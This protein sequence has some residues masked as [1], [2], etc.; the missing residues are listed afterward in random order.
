[1]KRVVLF[2]LA[3]LAHAGVLTLSGPVQILKG[4][5][6]PISVT[7]SG[8]AAYSAV[9]FTMV[10]P[11]DVIGVTVIPGPVAIA[12]QKSAR[13]GAIVSS[14]IS[15]IVAGFLGNVGATANS[16]AMADGVVAT[17]TVTLLANP[18][19][20]SE[21]FTLQPVSGANSAG[22]LTTTTAGP[23]L[24]IPVLTS[25]SLCDLNKDGK[26][27]AA[28]VTLLVTA[29]ITFATSGTVTVGTDLNSDGKVDLAD[30]VISLFAVPVLGGTCTAH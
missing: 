17:L 30:F 4:V 20:T 3:V 22:N 28:D 10:L 9:A 24:T 21:S 6:F 29:L 12:G 19:L 18:L 1:M 23:I 13:C 26:T 27:D 14:Q 7:S 15:C 8:G 25:F 16:T 2:L 5:P 11:S